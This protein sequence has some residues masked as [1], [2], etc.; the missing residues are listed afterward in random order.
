MEEQ[1]AV[2]FGTYVL[3]SFSCRGIGCCSKFSLSDGLV[4]G[5]GKLLFHLPNETHLVLTSGFR[6]K[7]HNNSI[8]KPDGQRA[9]SPRSRHM[10][11]EAADIK[12][13]GWSSLELY[14]FI[15][16]MA[17][18]EFVRG[19]IGIYQGERNFLHLD[20]RKRRTRFAYY[21]WDQIPFEEAIRGV[22]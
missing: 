7:K 12:V 1:Y 5:L 16:E 13:Q 22:A 17:I 10:L 18:P 11:G 21:N 6:C 9:S 3:P 19:C 14:E 8:M 2:L 4:N 20:I 15:E